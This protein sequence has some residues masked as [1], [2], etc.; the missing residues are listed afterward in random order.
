MTN[1]NK[2]I[3]HVFYVSQARGYKDSL[4]CITHGSIS[5]RSRRTTNSSED[6]AT[7]LHALIK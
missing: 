1:F 7:D 2:T 4:E 5:L 3:Q 6:F